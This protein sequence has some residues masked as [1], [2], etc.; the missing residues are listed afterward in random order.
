[1]AKEKKITREDIL[2]KLS[3]FQNAD[4]KFFPENHTYT[5]DGKF[6]TSATGY[7]DRFVKKFDEEFWSKKKAADAGVEQSAILEMWAAK[8]DRACD[9]GTMTHDYIENFYEKG[10]KLYP[11]DEEAMKRI[12]KFHKIHESKLSKLESIG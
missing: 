6:L 10:E 4:F 5:L 9:V 7:I 1:M 8:R 3:Y 12:A 11:N 2:N